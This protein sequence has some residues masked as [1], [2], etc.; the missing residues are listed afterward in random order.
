MLF[1]TQLDYPHHHPQFDF[2]EEVLLVAVD[3]YI[4]ILNGGSGLLEA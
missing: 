4:N 1:G 3:A 2:E